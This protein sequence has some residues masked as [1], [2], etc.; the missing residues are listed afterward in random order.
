MT[1]RQHPYP[2]S[3]RLKGRAA[4][5]AVNWWRPSPR[6]DAHVKIA[7]PLAVA[8]TL[9]AATFAQDILGNQPFIVRI[10]ATSSTLAEKMRVDSSGL[11]SASAFVG[12]GSQ[13]TNIVVGYTGA[14]I[15]GTNTGDD[16]MDAGGRPKAIPGGYVCLFGGGC[17]PGWKQYLHWSR[18]TPY[19]CSSGGCP[20]CTTTSHSTFSNTA[21]ETCSYTS[22]DGVNKCAVYSNKCFAQFFTVGCI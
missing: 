16:C 6:K 11:V 15:S 1:G 13:L 20:A 12:D 7:L 4:E 17:N 19:T 5:V 3:A 22:R 21:T 2:L 9:P 8:M 18:T 10:G 14:L